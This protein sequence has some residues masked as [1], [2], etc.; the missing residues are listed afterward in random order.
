MQNLKNQINLVTNLLR[1]SKY[2]EEVKKTIF[3]ALVTKGL[4]TSEES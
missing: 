2:K 1:D 3:L 4:I